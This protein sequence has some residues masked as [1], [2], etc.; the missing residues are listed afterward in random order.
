MGPLV[1]RHIILKIMSGTSCKTYKRPF[2]VCVE[3]NIGS[4]KT[5]FLNHF[6]SYNNTVVLQEP[7]EL[8]RDIS[9]V[10][11]LELMYKDPRRYAFIFQSYVQLTMLRLHTYKTQL[12]YKVM[13]R[14]VYCSRLFIENMK[15]NKILQD[16]EIVVLEEWYDWCIKNANIE[17]DLIIYLRTSPEVVYQ[18]MRIRARKEENSVSLEYLKQI[19]EIHDEWLLYQSLFS[20]PAP[21]II[22]D[23]NKSIEEMVAEFD[24]CK[25][26]IFT[27][28]REVE[29]EIITANT[30]M[31]PTHGLKE[32]KTIDM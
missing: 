17:T 13:E 4:G 25:N 6:K 29:N 27:Q 15:R 28:Q 1:R 26:K 12:P 2:T 3:G 21:V 16:V 22:L 7:V 5:T 9:G 32:I 19:H 10:N 8:W 24:K 23:G 20:L 18:R 31:S 11:L 14:S 30:T